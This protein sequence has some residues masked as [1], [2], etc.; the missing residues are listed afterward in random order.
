[1][2][3]D[4]EIKVTKKDSLENVEFSDNE[5][6]NFQQSRFWAEFKASHGWNMLALE[7]RI[8]RKDSVPHMHD[9]TEAREDGVSQVRD[10]IKVDK[11]RTSHDGDM[12]EI[13][14]CS[15]AHNVGALKMDENHISQ[16]RDMAKISENSVSYMSERVKTVENDTAHDGEDVKK[17]TNNTL[18]K[19]DAAKDDEISVS[20]NVGDIKSCENAVSRDGDAV[21]TSESGVS[22]ICDAAKIC[23][24]GI[25]H[26][27][28]NVKTDEN[29]VSR[30]GDALKTE[31]DSI[32]RGALYGENGF[33]RVFVLVRSFA[34]G[35]FSIAYVPMYPVFSSDSVS[36]QDF[37]AVLEEIAV[38][39]SPHLPKNTICV[40]FDPVLEFDSASMRDN[41]ISKVRCFSARNRYSL[42]KSDVDIQPPDTSLIDISRSE[43]EILASMKSKW[44]YN[45]NLASRKGVQIERIGVNE[46]SSSI[47]AVSDGNSCNVASSQDEFFSNLSKKV[48]E[49]YEVYRVTSARDGI[50]IHSKQYYLDLLQKS[51]REKFAGNDV[52]LVRLYIARHEDD[53]LGAIITLVTRNEGVYLYG[54]SSNVKRN[55][56]PN[57]L[58][59]WTAMRDARS[60]G[61]RIYDLYGIPPTDDARHPMHGLFLFKTGF[62]GKNIHRVGTFD[63]PLNHFYAF[64]SIAERTRAWWHKKFLK[65]IRGR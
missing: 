49:F 20:H 33:V 10:E 19:S 56:M 15:T 48:D 62:G 23:E 27:V 6:P 2:S 43:D 47:G 21:K 9:M 7:V 3:N 32:S 8:S 16:V 64:C 36:A 18:H 38:A 40:R 31:K 17:G 22:H 26:V 42:K 5:C 28:G 54:A 52:P 41:F 45:I 37:C 65:R 24:N 57:F 11:N 12:A 14:E 61:A 51:A 44:R 55:L 30:Y 29:T 34:K 46:V 1:M 39:V 53:V 13:G 59:Q 63:V 58:L 4:F 25:S 50:A 35:L 60:A